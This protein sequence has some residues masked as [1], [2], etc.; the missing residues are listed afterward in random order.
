MHNWDS[1]NSLVNVNECEKQVLIPMFC[2][3]FCYLFSSL[4]RRIDV[5][6]WPEYSFPIFRWLQVLGSGKGSSEKYQIKFCFCSFFFFSCVWSKNPGQQ[7]SFIIDKLCFDWVWPERER[8]ES[9]TKA[10]QRLK[11]AVPI[12][13]YFLV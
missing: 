6:R 13:L 3:F 11:W 12:K 2:C 7:P 1:S 9:I 4:L 8:K 10:K 5:D